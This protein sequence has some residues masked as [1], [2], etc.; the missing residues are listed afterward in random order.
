M[1]KRKFKR[2]LKNKKFYKRRIVKDPAIVNFILEHL[3]PA[4]IEFSKV[5]I[6]F[7]M[8]ANK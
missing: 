6:P 4:N 8:K 7:W 5:K 2:K 1:A 3:K